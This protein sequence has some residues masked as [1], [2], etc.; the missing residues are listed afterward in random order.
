MQQAHF[1]NIRS[2]ITAR[3]LEAQKEVVIA[4]A[5]FTS[6]E[7]FSAIMS[8]LSRDISVKLVLLENPINFMEYAPDFSR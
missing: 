1:N 3:L 8:C 6:A 4:M 7:L 5:W 2:K